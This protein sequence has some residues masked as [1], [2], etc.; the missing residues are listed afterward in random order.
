[1][2]IGS[3]RFK[4]WT[5]KNGAGTF[6]RDR[7]APYHCHPV[8]ASELPTTRQMA[9]MSESAFDNEISNLIYT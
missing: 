3:R 5:D 8:T 7:N 6:V 9:L 4:V 2:N 1:M